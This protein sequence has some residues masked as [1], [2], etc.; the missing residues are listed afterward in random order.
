MFY[1]YIIVDGLLM[2][3][4]YSSYSEASDALKRIQEQN[5]APGVFWLITDKE[6]SEEQQFQLC[7]I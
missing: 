6:L 2:D 3:N 7:N 5:K 1:A 4:Q